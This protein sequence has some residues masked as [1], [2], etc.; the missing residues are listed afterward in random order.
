ML[1]KFF[2]LASETNHRLTQQFQ[3]S[4]NFN[5]TIYTSLGLLGSFYIDNDMLEKKGHL[6]KLVS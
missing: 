5:L 1:T 2:F 4:F 6:M 3:L